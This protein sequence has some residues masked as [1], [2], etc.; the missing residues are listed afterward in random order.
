MYRGQWDIVSLKLS[1]TINPISCNWKESIPSFPFKVV[2]CRRAMKQKNGFQVYSG[3]LSADVFVVVIDM[4]VDS[5]PLTLSLRGIVMLT[6]I[7]T[8]VDVG[9]LI[10]TTSSEEIYFRTCMVI[11]VVD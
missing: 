2:E 7:Y 10:I 4:Y 11:Y 3:T 9:S 5:S 8:R 6:F 1:N